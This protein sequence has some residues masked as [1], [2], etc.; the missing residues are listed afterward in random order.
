[1]RGAKLPDTE[2][3]YF[4]KL[5]NKKNP[6]LPTLKPEDV[7][8]EQ[9]KDDFWTGK[10]TFYLKSVRKKTIGMTTGDYVLFSLD[11]LT[12]S[13]KGGNIDN[14]L[15]YVDGIEKYEINQIL[16]EE[17]T[18]K[19]AAR[20][21]LVVENLVFS[22]V[23]QYKSRFVYKVKVY[24][25]DR[26]YY[27]PSLLYKGIGMIYIKYIKEEDIDKLNLSDLHSDTRGFVIF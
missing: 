22:I 3:E 1:M 10:I 8:I 5:I 11:S 7:V 27:T 20:L 19:L 13:I 17:I 26:D 2:V 16:D 9:G 12:N 15:I 6:D 14:P 24:L 18:K 4:L 21:G 25:K 23:E